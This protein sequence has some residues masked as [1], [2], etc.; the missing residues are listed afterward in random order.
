MKARLRIRVTY[1]GT[2]FFTIINDGLYKEHDSLEKAK[3]WLDCNGFRGNF[4]VETIVNFS[5]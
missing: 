5:Y 2:K 1:E 4:K 3:D